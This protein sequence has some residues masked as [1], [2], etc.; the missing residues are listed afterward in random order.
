MLRES[1][2]R[3]RAFAQNGHPGCP[4]VLPTRPMAAI[5]VARQNDT[6]RMFSSL[7]AQRVDWVQPRRLPGRVQTKDDPHAG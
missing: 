7:V 3:Y 6:R 5:R 2:N 1:R 4:G